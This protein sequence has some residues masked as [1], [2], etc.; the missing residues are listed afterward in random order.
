MRLS[1]SMGSYY[2]PSPLLGKIHPKRQSS[3]IETD[4]RRQFRNVTS[5]CYS[6]K[7]VQKKLPGAENRRK[8]AKERE[9]LGP[10]SFVIM[11]KRKYQ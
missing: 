5:L 2:T 4:G 10:P 3:D 1:D 6:T 8:K 9:K 7:D 11:R